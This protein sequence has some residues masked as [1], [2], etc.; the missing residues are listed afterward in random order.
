MTFIRFD[1]WRRL[2]GAEAEIWLAGT[3]QRTGVIDEVTED[4]AIAWVA[5]DAKEPRRLFERA[6]GFELRICPEQYIFRAD[7]RGRH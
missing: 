5:A 6:S 1:D 4:S 7:I 3:L 2:R